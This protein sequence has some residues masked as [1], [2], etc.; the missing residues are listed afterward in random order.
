MDECDVLVT[1]YRSGK[2]YFKVYHLFNSEV[3]NYLTVIATQAARPSRPILIGNL[4]WMFH[5]DASGTLSNPHDSLL[6]Y[7]VPRGGHS[8]LQ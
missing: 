6:W 4:S 2:A 8:W 1:Q 3:Q 5:V 7:P